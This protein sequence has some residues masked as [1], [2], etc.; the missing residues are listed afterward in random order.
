MKRL[1]NKYKD[2]LMNG[3]PDN[4][5]MLSEPV[6]LKFRNG[7]TVKPWYSSKVRRVPL[8]QA[9]EAKKMIGDML[10]AGI[11]GK[12]QGYSDWCSPATFVVKKP[13]GLMLV[14]DFT[15][16]NKQVERPVHPFPTTEDIQR[17][18]DPNSRYFAN[19]DL[20]S[21]YHQIPLDEGSEG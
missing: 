18:I 10:Q 9:P 4:H 3:L 15:M 12:A 8:H 13:T 19:I 14:M 6:K 5:T 20:C 21:A 16:L 17:S 2:V 7:V 1:K 11:I